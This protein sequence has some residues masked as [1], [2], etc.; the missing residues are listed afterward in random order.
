MSCDT[1][2]RLARQLHHNESDMDGASGRHGMYVC[3]I[4]NL[5]AGKSFSTVLRH[6]GTHRFDPG[7]HILCGINSCTE[8][9]KNFESFRSHIYRKHRDALLTNEPHRDRTPLNPIGGEIPEPHQ[10][11]DGSNRTDASSRDDDDTAKKMAAMF[12]L[13]TR[14]ERKVTQVALDGIIQ[15]FRGIWRSA[16]QVIAT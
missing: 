12:L 9:Y 5:F 11:D 1:R 10:E 2:A 7:L 4:C 13:K 16:L 3:T 6:M 14:E 15:D 8:H